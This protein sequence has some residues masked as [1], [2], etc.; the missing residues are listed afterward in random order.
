[1][2]GFG[3]FRNG[4]VRIPKAIWLCAWLRVGGKDDGG[5]CL[6]ALNFRD[7]PSRLSSGDRLGSSAVCWLVKAAG[8][9]GRWVRVSNYLC[10][11]GEMT[12][13]REI[14]RMELYA[15]VHLAAVS[16]TGTGFHDFEFES[17]SP[18]RLSRREIS[19][20]GPT[21][22][23]KLPPISYG[24]PSINFTF[25]WSCTMEASSLGL[26]FD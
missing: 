2:G 26:L 1:M 25:N 23:W 4:R 17:G 14:G 13:G 9:C 11:S 16:R 6:R 15:T 8:R 3:V 7:W 21:Y 20:M 18:H 19:T 10:T 22:T 24:P 5:Y 12:G